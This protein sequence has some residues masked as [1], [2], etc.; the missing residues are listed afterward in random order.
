MIQSVW[1]MNSNGQRL[2]IN[3]R[4]SG[5]A[6]GLYLYNIEGMGTPSAAVNGV[7]GPSFDGVVVNSVKVD[8]RQLVITLATPKQGMEEEIVKKMVY[9]HFPFTEYVRFGITTDA[10]DVYIDAIVESVESNPFAKVENYVIGLYCPRPY[11]RDATRRDYSIT[12]SSGIP[13]FQFPFSNNSL[14]QPL[15]I[16]GE[17]TTL[18]S[19]IIPYYDGMTTGVEI[20][21]NLLGYA[22]DIMITNT[23][24]SQTMGL[25]LDG[26]ETQ[27]GSVRAGD[28][29]II[30]T[31]NG[32][33]SVT[34]HRDGIAY[35]IINAI[36]I[37]QNWIKLHPGINTV[38]VTAGQGEEFIVTDIRFNQIRGLI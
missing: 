33:K 10:H 3:L 24:R 26:I 38:A 2:D 6:L 35:N 32:E 4:E 13:M 28:R 36:L 16:F 8:P 29:I 23:N 5:D 17:I 19:A 18:P 7:G 1:V 14:I 27:V 25:W 20:T 31:N 12:S 22:S 9:N 37:G 21:L 11:W 30:N 15:L 34:F